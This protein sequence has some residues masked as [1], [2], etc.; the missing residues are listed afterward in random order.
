MGGEGESKS[1]GRRKGGG[2]HM[3]NV[4]KLFLENHLSWSNVIVTSTE[5]DNKQTKNTKNK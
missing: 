4:N 3:K 2:K 1:K 5:P